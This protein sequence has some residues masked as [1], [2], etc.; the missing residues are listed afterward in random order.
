MCEFKFVWNL[1][2]LLIFMK[3]FLNSD[4]MVSLICNY[5][6]KSYQ[7]EVCIAIHIAI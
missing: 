3:G 5:N 6:F 7:A 2:L 1:P 4:L